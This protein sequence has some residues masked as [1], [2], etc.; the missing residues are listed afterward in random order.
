MSARGSLFGVSW[1]E[2]EHLAVKSKVWLHNTIKFK[3]SSFQKD[4]SNH[5]TLSVDKDSIY[6][7]AVLKY[8]P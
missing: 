2:S 1:S 5:V 4:S 8:N 7:E 6:R 3:V